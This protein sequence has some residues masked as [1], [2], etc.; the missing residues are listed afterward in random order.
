MTHREFDMNKEV[1]LAKRQ[2]LSK[3]LSA[4]LL[5]SVVLAG[6][7]PNT[8]AESE[9]TTVSETAQSTNPENAVPMSDAAKATVEEFEAEFVAKMLNV[10]ESQLAEYEALQAADKPDGSLL[11]T[12]ISNNDADTEAGSPVAGNQT[13]AMTNNGAANTDIQNPNAKLESETQA[14]AS[15]EQAQT[16]NQIS[17]QSNTADNRQATKAA[18]DTGDDTDIDNIEALALEKLPLINNTALVAPQMLTANEI[19]RR[20]NVA[21][22]SLYLP[23]E[24][25]LPAEAMDTLL[26]I[27][28]LTPDLFANSELAQRLVI[29]SPALARL[30]R[31]YQTWQQI[32]LQQSKELESLK[33]KQSEEFDN[34]VR[35]FTAKIESYDEQIAK[36]EERLKQFE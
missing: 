19:S 24:V 8:E 21:L 2:S 27:A 6:C 3:A 30:L 14:T 35:E 13:N 23:E 10:Q 34:L 1:H 32:Q 4:I 25:P 7:Q 29:K 18:D 9:E 31:Q 28:T 36:Y 16:D 22:Q 11:D 15:T 12:A 17:T 26:N 20:Y 5:S 33:Q